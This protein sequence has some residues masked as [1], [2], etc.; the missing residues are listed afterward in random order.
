MSATA[1]RAVGCTDRTGEHKAESP[2][3]QTVL[4]LSVMNE[5][6]PRFHSDRLI[7]CVLPDLLVWGAAVI[8]FCAQQHEIL[9]SILSLFVCLCVCLSVCLFL[10][11]W[12][13]HS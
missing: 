11:V 5:F 3:S 1:A 12:T 9:C 6:V 13:R 8:Y 7:V 2:G 4:L 10:I